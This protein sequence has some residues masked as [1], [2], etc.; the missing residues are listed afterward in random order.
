[1]CNTFALQIF[2]TTMF[3]AISNF[4]SAQVSSEGP[5]MATGFYAEG[6]IY[7]VIGVIAIILTGIF[8]YLNK[9]DRKI[10]KIENE[11]NNQ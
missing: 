10:K 5:E 6:K 2:T 8:I 3:L 9:L 1:M 11:I 4:A 7:V